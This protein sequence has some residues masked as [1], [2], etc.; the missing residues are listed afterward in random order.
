MKYLITENQKS[1]LLI[2][3]INSGEV[4]MA[5][6]LVGGINNLIK[7]VGRSKIMDI[8][9]S[10]FDNLKIVRNGNNVSLISGGLTLMET[11][12]I[13]LIV[14]DDYIKYYIG[15]ELEN[16]YTDNR[17]SLIKKLVSRFPE[18]YNDKVRVYKDSGRYLKI[19]EFTL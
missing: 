10:K 6:D 2:N 19:T 13:G 14:Y 8:L 16:F 5:S 17:K 4:D 1:K 7:I 12:W 9:I 18:L 3:L 15:D 11:S